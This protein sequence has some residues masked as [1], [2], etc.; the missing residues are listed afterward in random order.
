M[1]PV[2][3]IIAAAIILAVCAVVGIIVWEATQQE[4]AEEFGCCNQ[5]VSKALKRNKITRKKDDSL[6]RTGSGKS[7]GVSRKL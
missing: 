5:A 3:M 1:R 4:M 6:Q 7:K 2:I